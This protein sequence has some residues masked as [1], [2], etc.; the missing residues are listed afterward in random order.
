MSEC[1]CEGVCMCMC[2]YISMCVLCEC[3]CDGMGVCVAVSHVFSGCEWESR[4]VCVCENMGV[5][6]KGCRV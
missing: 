4:W 2:M 5:Y 3:G 6:E 1:D